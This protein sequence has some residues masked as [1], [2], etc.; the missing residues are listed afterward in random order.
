MG[1]KPEQKKDFGKKDAKAPFKQNNKQVPA[2]KN[3]SSKTVKK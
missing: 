3:I 1:F 2:G